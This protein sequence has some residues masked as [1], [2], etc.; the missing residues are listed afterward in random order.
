MARPDSIA[1]GVQPSSATTGAGPGVRWVNRAVLGWLVLVLAAV[2]LVSTAV[3]LVLTWSAPVRPLGATRPVDSA[4]ATALFGWSA[5]GALVVFRRPDNRVGLILLLAGLAGQTW[6]LGSYYSAFGLLVRPG[7]VPAAEAAVSTHVWLPMVAFGLAF[8]FLLLLF[9]DGRLP[10]TGWRPFAWFAGAGLAFW[11]FTWGTAPG[12]VDGEFGSVENPAGIVWIEHVDPGV[13]WGLFVLAVLG[14]MIAVLVRLRRSSGVERAQLKWFAYAA[15]VIGLTWMT[16]TI[17][18]DAGP[19]FTTIGDL[20]FPVAVGAVPLAVFIAV[21]RHHLYDIDLVISRTIVVGALAAL[22]TG[23]YVAVVALAGTV[24]G[25]AGEVSL[26]VAMVAAGLVAVVFQPVRV[27]AQR[28]ANRLVYGTRAAPYE[29]LTTLARRMG[30]TY[31]ADDLMPELARTLAQGTG[32]ARAEVWLRTDRR[33][34]RAACWPATDR[35]AVPVVLPPD[36][37]KVMFPAPSCTAEVR[38]QGSLVGALVVT[39]PPGRSMSTVEHRLLADLAAQVGVSLDNLRLVEELKASRQRIVTAQDEERRRL[40]RDIHDG[41]Q[42]RLVS[43]SLAL[44]MAAKESSSS[45]LDEAAAEARAALEELR[46][47]ARGIHPAIVSEGGLAAALESLAERSP[48][49]TAVAGAMPDG[50]P[51]SVE[52]TAYYVV[53]E[54]LANVAKHARATRAEVRV[55]PVD[56]AVYVEVADDGVGG[57]VA[58]R[59]SGLAGLADRVSALGG[60]IEVDSPAGKGTRLRVEIPCGSS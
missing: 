23:G 52:V 7:S 28:L 59:G 13:G 27:R 58:G 19:P 48:V 44:A 37:D 4:V 41:V 50:L 30:G 38:H 18:S 57:A 17:G 60:A 40:E 51:A 16:V 14:S 34:Y 21:F 54:A 42:Q 9:P 24:I 8:T 55:G 33:L 22:V 25:R 43:L 12:P 46:R 36:G 47:L 35:P 1:T 10:S 56:G 49:P 32:A 6:V 15:V 2:L 11:T 5:V 31:A 26:G 45:G 53:A 20:M 39:L 29:V 3:L